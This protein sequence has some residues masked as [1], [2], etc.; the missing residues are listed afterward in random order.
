MLNQT[1]FTSLFLVCVVSAVLGIIFGI[2]GLA[3]KTGYTNEW[4]KVVNCT[5]I[6]TTNCSLGLAHT[7]FYQTQSASNQVF[8]SVQPICRM[9]FSSIFSRMSITI[10]EGI[11]LLYSKRYKI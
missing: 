9:I 2:S 5:C 3:Y 7:L 11:E 4:C 10:I 1:R 8:Q 6:D